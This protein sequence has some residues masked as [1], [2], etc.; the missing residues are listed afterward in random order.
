MDKALKAYFN[1]I[2]ECFHCP[3]APAPHCPPATAG[4][5]WHRCPAWRACRRQRWAISC[6]HDGNGPCLGGQTGFN[7][8]PEHSLAKYVKT[9]QLLQTKAMA[10]Q[11]RLAAYDGAS[12]F[13]TSLWRP[14]SWFALRSKY[15]SMIHPCAARAVWRC[16]RMRCA[17]SAS[18]PLTNTC[19][20]MPR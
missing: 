12:P 16:C 5:R 4:P 13:I 17:T 15:V 14:G 2:S 3:A 20:G 11:I 10:A 6:S 9:I 18:G 19:S 8:Y 1:L 7:P